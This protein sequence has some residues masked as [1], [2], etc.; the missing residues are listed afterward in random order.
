MHFVRKASR[1]PFLKGDAV[2]VERKAAC[3]QTLAPG[4][5]DADDLGRK[6]QHLPELCFLRRDLFLSRLALRDVGH[7]SDKLSMAG[8]VLYGVPDRVD[9]L[10]SSIRQQQATL[11]FEVTA[12]LRQVIDDLLRERLV[13]R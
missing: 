2:I 12:N 7:R 3:I 9:L 1:A 10:D 11:M 5:Q 8:R 6:I 4:V 13:I